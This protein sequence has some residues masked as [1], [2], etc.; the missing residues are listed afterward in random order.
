[1]PQKTPHRPDQIR[2][3]QAIILGLSALVMALLA[4]GSFPLARALSGETSLSGKVLPKFSAQMRD[5][6]T[7]TIVWRDG[8]YDLVKQGS[9]WVMPQRGNYPVQAETLANLAKGLSELSYKTLRTSDPAQFARLGVGPPSASSPGAL[10][11]FKNPAG[12]ILESL[13]I[14]RRGDTILVRK[15]GSNDVFEV[16]GTLPELGSPALWLDLQVIDIAPETIASVSGQRRGDARYDIVRRP[17][18]GFAPVGGSANVTATAAAIALTKW[19]P[20]EVAL[21]RTL[22]GEPVATHVTRLRTGLVISTSAYD[23]MGHNWVR[24]S[25]TSDTADQIGAAA[26]L[27]QR[28]EDWAFEVSAADFADLTFAR[29][30]IMSTKNSKFD[31]SQ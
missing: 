6:Q 13:Y 10:V 1:M 23:A 31:E 15:S 20:V 19:A 28:L 8:R 29:A 7:I 3:R 24:L 21:A 30:A 18:E 4:L 16:S 12:A 27:N 17:D 26:T 22:T 14:G 11:S 9:T 25:A 5:I 2:R